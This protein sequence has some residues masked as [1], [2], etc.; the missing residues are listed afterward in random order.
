MIKIEAK[1]AREASE[2][3]SKMRDDSG[4]G[5]STFPNGEWNGN[6]ISYNGRV[7]KGVIKYLDDLT[8]IIYDPRNR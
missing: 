4:E 8:E 7:W 3:Y 6:L 1:T 5:C 2:I